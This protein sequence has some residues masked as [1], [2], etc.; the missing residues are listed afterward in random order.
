MPQKVGLKGD[1]QTIF[2]CVGS[3]RTLVTNP[4]GFPPQS[5]ELASDTIPRL[6]RK[7]PHNLKGVAPEFKVLV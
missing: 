3:S 2:K 1:E 4:K 6:K 5:P 7:N